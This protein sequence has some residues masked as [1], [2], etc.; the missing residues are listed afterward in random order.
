MQLF[1]LS[2]VDSLFDRVGLCYRAYYH[3]R[4]SKV[5]KCWLWSS[6]IR[7]AKQT[8]LFLVVLHCVMC[9]SFSCYFTVASGCDFR[10]RIF[11]CTG[12][13]WNLSAYPELKGQVL[14]LGLEILT[15]QVIIPYSEMVARQDGKANNLV[16]DDVFTNVVGVLRYVY[17]Q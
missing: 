15:N 6:E 7:I 1:F 12:T 5:T 10:I 9:F 8:H 11:C 2:K 14:E 16:M 4:L 13:L 3:F 17:A